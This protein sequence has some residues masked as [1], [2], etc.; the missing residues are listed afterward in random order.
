MFSI[1]IDADS[2]P[3]PHRAIVLK[4]LVKESSFFDECI[5]A[6]DRILSDV[7]DV[8]EAHTASLRR[9]LRETLDKD[10]I[11]KIKSNIKMVVVPVGSNSA[12]D[13]LVENCTSPGFAITHD[14]PLSMRLIEKGI[15]VIDD[16]GH[17]Y[18]LSNIKERLSER[19]FMTQMREIG[20]MCEKTKSFD[21][22]T[23]N[24]FA[25]SF[26]SVFSRYIKDFSQ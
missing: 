21:Q 6:S 2:L 11:R 18:D 15:L 3:K 12:D 1:Y 22:K 9:P 13:Y 7:R 25:S 14:V 26:D 16:R 23:L 17:I 10:E 20:Y 4:R 5:F 8:I 19:N 24:E